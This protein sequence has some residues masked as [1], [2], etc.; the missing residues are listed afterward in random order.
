MSSKSLQCGRRNSVRRQSSGSDRLAMP[1]QIPLD[2]LTCHFNWDIC[3]IT[4]TTLQ[5]R[6]LSVEGHLK[7]NSFGIL[8]QSYCLLAY[9]KSKLA[10]SVEMNK[11]IYDLL[12]EAYQTLPVVDQ[13]SKKEG[14][15][16]KAV[17][18]ANLTYWESNLQH[19]EKAK[20]HFKAY[21]DF[22]SRYEEDLKNHPEVL[23]MKA[24]A[25]G[26]SFGLKK[27]RLSVE[28]YSKALDDSSYVNK[29]EWIFGLALSKSNVALKEEP[30]ITEDLVEIEILLRRTIQIDPKYSLA[31]LK[32]AKTLVNLN[33]VSVFEEAEHWI[34]KALD[35]S[36][37]KLSCLEEAASIYQLTV[38][39]KKSNN[40][41]AMILYKE[42]EKINP[43]SKRTILGLGKCYFNNYQNNKRKGSSGNLILSYKMVPKDLQ[44]AREYFEK[45]SKHKRHTD[46]LKLA[47]VYQEI[48]LFEGYKEY[49]TKAENIYKKVITLTKE[50]KDS[51]HLIEA[52]TRYA[53]FLKKE[54]RVVEEIAYLKK[55]VDVTVE[56]DNEEEFEMRFVRKCQDRLLM[57]ASQG[58][59]MTKMESLALKG[60]V[61]GKRGN[62]ITSCYYLQ[63]ALKVDGSEISEDYENQLK[64]NLAGRTL[65]VSQLSQPPH[66]HAMKQIY[67]AKA[68]EMI[69]SLAKT[70]QKFEL[71]FK[72]AEIEINELI[73]D[74]VEQLKELK[75]YYLAFEMCCK[76]E[77]LQRLHDKNQ[78]IKTT[79]QQEEEIMEKMLDVI[80]ESKRILDRSINTVKKSIFQKD[81]GSP[82]T[83]YYPTP[84]SFTLNEEVHLE[85][86]MQHL[87]EKRFKLQDF[88]DRLPVLFD[89]LV[90]KQPDPSKGK[91]KWF[92]DAIDIRNNREHSTESK[93]LLKEKFKTRD[94][95]RDLINQISQYAVEIWKGV[96]SETITTLATQN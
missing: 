82:P 85:Q 13:N 61:L 28:Y 69:A 84:K 5:E 30:Q 1:K 63:E 46:H 54:E 3:N 2:S 26:Y 48:S 35:V 14:L 51:L 94:K 16:Y 4:S 53:T 39:D 77:N 70:D 60:H 17:V 37:R 80:T 40:G 50:E 38:S 44:K 86:Q 45:D 49:K 58:R 92:Q 81:P 31:M 59:Y 95:Q 72:V 36:D 65:Y 23:A 11:E 62:V 96:Q 9:L 22:Q 75:K 76:E 71:E 67:F 43:T 88:K 79:E 33:G 25:F 91:Y 87:L 19:H 34:N 18:L 10:P 83:C 73:S 7:E 74:K 27:S 68:K 42:A 64:E 66:A 32:L 6:I 41:K 55:A 20:D 8:P 12:L 93:K 56:C 47:Q 90:D 15:G 78:N 21:K 52:Y 89:F 24:F 57:Y 29:A